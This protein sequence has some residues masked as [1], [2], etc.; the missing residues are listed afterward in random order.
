M[1]KSI[2]HLHR[3][4][5]NDLT[6]GDRVADRLRNILASWVFIIG[7]LVYM[8]MWIMIAKLQLF[9]LDNPQLTYLNLILSCAAAL[10]SSV[11]LLA[12]KRSDV[13]ASEVAVHTQDNT[14]M[15]LQLNRQQLEILEELRVIR[16]ELGGEKNV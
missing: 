12:Q 10:A 3:E 13:I 8:G 9:P 14:E 5:N 11:I 7:S 2:W 16:A 1:K 6:V 15:L 4:V